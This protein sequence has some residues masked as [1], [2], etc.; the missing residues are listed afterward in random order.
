MEATV[1]GNT[2]SVNWQDKYIDKLSS[3]IDGIKGME[4]RLTS[5]IENRMERLELRMDRMELRID[6]ME[7]NH[8]EGLRFLNQ[9]VDALDEKINANNKYTHTLAVTCIAGI[10]AVTVGILGIIVAVIIA[11][12]NIFYK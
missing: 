9:K 1:N 4:S 10:G 7:K 8:G 5:Y 3:D 2:S 6:S 12:L 11:L